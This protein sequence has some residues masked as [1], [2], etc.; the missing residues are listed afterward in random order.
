M[1]ERGR[2]GKDEVQDMLFQ[3]TQ[4]CFNECDYVML[5]SIT[6][7][8]NENNANSCNLLDI[9]SDNFWSW[10]FN[11]CIKNY[12]TRFSYLKPRNIFILK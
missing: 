3:I 1:E 4:I 5:H 7:I 11:T 6:N 2:E 8:V 10:V 12:H 9:I